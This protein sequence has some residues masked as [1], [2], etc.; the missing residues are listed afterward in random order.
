MLMGGPVNDWGSVGIWPHIRIVSIRAMPAGETTFPFHYYE[1]AILACGKRANSE[2]VVAVNLSL[3][4]VGATE[5]QVERLA[6]VVRNARRQGLTVSAAAGNGRGEVE[7][8]AAVPDVTAIGAASE[9]GALCA[10]SAHGPALDIV[11]PGCGLDASLADG[12]A[13]RASGTSDAAA[14]V[15]AVLAAL[16]SYRPSLGATEAENLLLRT[17]RDTGDAQV[18]DAEAAFRA[19]GLGAIVDAGNSRVPRSSEGP[20]R[21]AEPHADLAP[22]PSASLPRPRLRFLRR[23]VR[24]LLVRVANRPSGATVTATVRFMA[25]RGEF[26]SRTRTAQRAAN[27]ISIRGRGRWTRLELRFR[28]ATG[29][30]SPALVVRPRVPAPDPR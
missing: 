5:E 8:P 10:F 30:T 13:A 4:G 21:P 16:R 15:S 12:T 17:A 23:T 22:A 11:A 24:K 1:Q 18:V 25:G 20:A 27:A 29:E 2:R 7:Y 14:I 9:E 6:D 26:R 19:A 28:A 3:G